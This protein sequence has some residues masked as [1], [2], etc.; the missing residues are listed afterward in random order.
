MIIRCE[1]R[2]CNCDPI[3]ERCYDCNQPST[4]SKP[5]GPVGS[6]DLMVAREGDQQ[7]DTTTQSAGPDGRPIDSI[8]KPGGDASY[9]IE[10]FLDADGCVKHKVN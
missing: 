4:T 6:S 10:P 9:R 5:A 8:E 3:Y 1:Q 2:N 7:R